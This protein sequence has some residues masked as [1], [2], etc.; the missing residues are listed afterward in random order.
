MPLP[1]QR[2]GTAQNC[3]RKLSLPSQHDCVCMQDIGQFIAALEQFIAPVVWVAAQIYPN[4]PSKRS[5]NHCALQLNEFVQQATQRLPHVTVLPVAAMQL[6][7][8]DLVLLTLS[9]RM[10]VPCEL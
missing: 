8:F 4:T 2:A 7:S 5:Y 3:E 10:C 1:S 6:G 9:M